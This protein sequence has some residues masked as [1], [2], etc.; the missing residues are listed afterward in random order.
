VGWGGVGWGGVGWGGGEGGGTAS[1][2]HTGF[3][4]LDEACAVSKEDWKGGTMRELCRAW[5]PQASNATKYLPRYPCITA[6][7]HCRSTPSPAQACRPPSLPGPRR[8]VP[9]HVPTRPVPRG[10]RGTHGPCSDTRG[11]SRVVPGP[12]EHPGEDVGG[13]QHHLRQ[14]TWAACEALTVGSLSCF[15]CVR[16]LWVQARGSSLKV[17]SCHGVHGASVDALQ[18]S[19]FVAAGARHGRQARPS[20]PP[21]HRGGHCSHRRAGHAAPRVQ[22]G[23]EVG[24]NTHL[25][26]RCILLSP[27]RIRVAPLER[28]LLL[29]LCCHDAD[30]WVQTM[31][32]ALLADGGT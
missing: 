16:S 32:I 24:R 15:F 23:G 2:P 20:G 27:V 21:I 31:L 29:G 22:E 14:R 1:L 4:D 26:F 30:V 6:M 5:Q 25:V 13:V 9:L 18:C 11:G 17:T 3:A 12:N 28:R 10:T 8:A 7:A 19:F